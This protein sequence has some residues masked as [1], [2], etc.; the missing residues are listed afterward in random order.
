MKKSF[1]YLVCVLMIGF[2]SCEEVTDN[3]SYYRD[4]PAIVGISYGTFQ[5]VILTSFGLFNAPELQS[6]IYTELEEGDAIWAYFYV[7]HDKPS[8]TGEFIAYDLLYSKLATGRSLATTGGVSETGDF[9]IPIEKMWIADV[10]GNIMFF[11]FEQRLPR[12]QKMVYELTYDND[13]TSEPVIYFRAKKDYPEGKESVENFHYA[14]SFNMN[15]FFTKYKN[16][17]GVVKFKIKYKT[18]VDSEGNEKYSNYNNGELVEV[19][20]Q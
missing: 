10:I 6:S 5:P 8:K 9:D 11:V 17:D 12:D 18:G 16:S 2:S 4:V 15:S 1:F 19:K 14:F 3:I 7:N 20:V 13:Q